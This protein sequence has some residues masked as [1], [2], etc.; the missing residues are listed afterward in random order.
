[1]GEL[2]G[3]KMDMEVLKTQEENII[4]D[5]IELIH[6]FNLT[7]KLSYLYLGKNEDGG[8]K[9]TKEAKEGFKPCAIIDLKTPIHKLQDSRNFIIALSNLKSTY[10]V[11]YKKKPKDTSDKEDLKKKSYRY[12]IIT[13]L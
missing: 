12:M 1:M 4:S 10:K 7:P 11:L 5:M 8:L 13:L 2:K 9:F 3:L 6:E